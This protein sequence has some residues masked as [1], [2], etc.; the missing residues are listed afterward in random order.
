M[1]KE[2]RV[3]MIKAMEYIAR[4]LN[5]E[6]IFEP[7]LS[8][9][10]ADGDIEYGSLDITSDDIENLDYYIEDDNFKDLMALFLRMM[11]R[12]NESGLYCD[13]VVSSEEKPKKW[14]YD[15]LDCGTC[16]YCGWKSDEAIYVGH[17]YCPH[18]GKKVA[19]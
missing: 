13:G 15:G 11:K 10:V 7:W 12:A 17:D 6:E 14:I 3:K 4:N 1:N 2:R 8:V 5:D 18:C 9:G 19:Q 16:P